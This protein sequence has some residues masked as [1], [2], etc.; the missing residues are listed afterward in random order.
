MP[1]SYPAAAEVLAPGALAGRRALVTGGG[2][3]IGR[4]VALQLARAGADVAV[5]GR[6][7]EP[8]DDT[9]R[10][11]AEAAPQARAISVTA[12]VREPEQV[13]A[14]LDQVLAEFGALEVLVNNAGGQ[15][16]SPA[17]QISYKG[18]RAVTR[19]NLDATWYLGTQVAARTM[20]P[21]GYGKI[22]S[23]TMTPRRGM[24]GMSHSS[25][26]RAAVESLAR[27]WAVEWGRYGIRTTAVA[28]GI[29]HTEAWERY[30][31]EPGQIASVVPVGRL[32]A[33]EE[34]AA[35]VGFLASPAGDYITGTTI[36]VDGG[37]DVSGPGSAFGTGGGAG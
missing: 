11:L 31:L 28:P 32:Q 8:L 29:V 26:A 19:L 27:T 6:R 35:T 15:F 33:A 20:I 21:A 34:V 3:G 1:A 13:D 18:F 30:G 12:D 4:A 17:E 24:P 7:S 9:C 14:A 10:I 22:I 37:L 25:A 16:V 23:I 36:V 5:L 2:S